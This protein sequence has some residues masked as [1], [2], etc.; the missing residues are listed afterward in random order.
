MLGRK[1]RLLDGCI[2]QWCGP[3]PPWPIGPVRLN[4]CA[5]TGSCLI[6]AA[7]RRRVWTD[8]ADAFVPMAWLAVGGLPVTEAAFRIP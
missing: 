5:C 4:G 1:A 2:R 6:R 7:N 3:W 8:H